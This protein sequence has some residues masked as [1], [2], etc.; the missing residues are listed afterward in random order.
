MS[1]PAQQPVF[2][3]APHRMMFF[4]GAVQM[5]VVLLFW[6]TELVGRYTRL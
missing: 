6:G 3:A 5:V 4:A 1:R 2:S